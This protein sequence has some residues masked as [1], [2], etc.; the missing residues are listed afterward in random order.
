MI[1][2]RKVNRVEVIDHRKKYQDTEQ[3]GRTVI[4][5]GPVYGDE[6]KAEVFVHLQDDKRTLKIFIEDAEDEQE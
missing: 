5:A 2:T 3:G 1:D 6:D 4:L